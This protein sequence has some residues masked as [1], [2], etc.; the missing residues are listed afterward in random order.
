MNAAAAIKAR[1]FLNKHEAQGMDPV[2]YF[3][4]TGRSR[5]NKLSE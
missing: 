4:A 3:A 5:N 2:Q 1:P